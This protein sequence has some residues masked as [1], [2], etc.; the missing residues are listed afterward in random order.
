MSN[1]VV[2][3]CLDHIVLTVASIPN[4]ISFFTTHLGMRHETFASQKDPSVTRHALSF[5]AGTATQKINLHQA[6]A[7]FIP[8]AKLATP[9]SADV[10]FV[11]DTPVDEVLK[12]WKEGGLKI[13][14]EGR[15]VDRMGARGVLRSVYTRDPDGN[16]IE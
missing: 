13:L 5:G 14:E 10:C 15:V 6:G 3:K 2:V 16:L 7:E 4:T 12:S 11:S 1:K 8:R 9:G